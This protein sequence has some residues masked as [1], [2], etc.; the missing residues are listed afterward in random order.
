MLEY[1]Q[2]RDLEIEGF[3]QYFYSAVQHV[4]S[5]HL[6]QAKERHWGIFFSVISSG[7]KQGQYGA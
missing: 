3:L 6:G 1:T 2:I 4:G 5:G 7:G